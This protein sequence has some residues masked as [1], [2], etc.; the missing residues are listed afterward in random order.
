[1]I[2]IPINDNQR[3]ELKKFHE[4]VVWEIIEKRIS[5]LEMIYDNHNKKESKPKIL[6]DIS[7]LSTTKKK[8]I[9][10]LCE[11][12]ANKKSII[13]KLCTIQPIYFK[14]INKLVE[15]YKKDNKS[16]ISKVVSTLGKDKL[17]EYLKYIF[18]FQDYS[19]N[20]GYRFVELVNIKVCPYCN[21]NYI[22]SATS[23]PA[24]K[25]T[26]P[27]I[28]HFYPKSDY[29][30]LA[31]SLYNLIPSCK[32][33]NHKKRNEFNQDLLNLY[34]DDLVDKFYFNAF[35]VNAQ[36]LFN[37]VMDKNYE[38]WLMH[39]NDKSVTAHDGIFLLEKRYNNFSDIINEI[40]CKQIIYSSSYI[41]NLVNQHDFIN[42]YEDAY[43]L[44]WGNYCN[45]EDFYKRP[46]AK[47]TSDIVK[48]FCNED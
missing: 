40:I 20:H 37:N 7:D 10:L 12:I 13:C 18:N 11:C 45:V 32:V 16:I 43:R 39:E 22:F 19:T 35:P 24:D 4:K 33:C 38:V 41:E 1:M 46:L 28:D 2:K 48:Q 34:K 47:F 27:D 3:E 8:T 21:M 26:R 15:R 6:K 44:V 5:K 17:H 31:L 14:T 29:P 42:S 36:S 30:W 25:G 23:K 9:K